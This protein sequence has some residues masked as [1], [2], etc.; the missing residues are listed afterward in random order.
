MSNKMRLAALAF[1]L[2]ACLALAGCGTGKVNVNTTAPRKTM[3]NY[4]TIAITVLNDVGPKCPDDVAPALQAAAIKQ[5]K[6]KYPDVFA[7]VRTAST[8]AEGEL[9]VEVHIIKYNKG[10]RLARAMLIGL[11]SSKITTTLAFLDSATKTPLATGE[12]DLTWA[13]GGII[14]ASKGIE[15]LV[16]SAGTKIATAIV[17]TRTGK[18]VQK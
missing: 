15:D 18:P 11:G 10:S 9:L 5:I 16:E 2:A 4:Q 7:D 1:G 3:E 13:I 6:A 12:L 17:E 8:G 14:G